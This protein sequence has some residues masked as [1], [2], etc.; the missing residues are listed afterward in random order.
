M[1]KLTG[2]RSP[3]P[4]IRPLLGRAECD[5]ADQITELLLLMQRV[6]CGIRFQEKRRDGSVVAGLPEVDKRVFNPPQS[7]QCERKADG[8]D[9]GGFGSFFQYREDSSGSR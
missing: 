9:I 3:T 2:H 5:V 1:P 7:G 4:P 8:G 6:P